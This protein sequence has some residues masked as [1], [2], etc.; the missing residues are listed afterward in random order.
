[1]TVST[2]MTFLKYF[3]LPLGFSLV[4]SAS[5]MVSTVR[6][7]VNPMV[8]IKG[9]GEGD[10]NGF[11]PIIPARVILPAPPDSNFDECGE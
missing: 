9:A 2:L 5:W 3:V 6:P 7:A 4:L 8:M 11:M 1:M 10:V